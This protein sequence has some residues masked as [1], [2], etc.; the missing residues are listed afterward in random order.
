MSDRVSIKV[1]TVAAKFVAKYAK[2]RDLSEGE[3]ADKLISVAE[4]RL[5]ALARYN[6][7]GGPP[8][9]AKGKKAGKKA[10]KKAVKAKPAKK[11]A[12][13]AK[14]AAKAKAKTAKASSKKVGKAKASGKGI[15]TLNGTSKE[16]TESLAEAAE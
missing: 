7:K 1:S 16:A 6:E 4:T 9:A 8:K 14:K 10:S 15:K 13:G 5:A 12:K 2:Q 11:A 3:A